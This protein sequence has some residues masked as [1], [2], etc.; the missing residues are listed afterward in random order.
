MFDHIEFG[1][2]TEAI[3]GTCHTNSRRVCA[4]FH[5]VGGGT[6]LKEKKFCV[7]LMFGS[8]FSERVPFKPHEICVTTG[9]SV[10]GRLCIAPRE[11][12]DSLVRA[13]WTDFPT[14]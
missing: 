6:D 9:L 4:H 5:N 13:S 1:T 3:M 8:F 12:L 10:N 14:N 11:H 2:L 7:D